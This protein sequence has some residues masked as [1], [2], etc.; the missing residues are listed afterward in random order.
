MGVAVLSSA[1]FENPATSRRAKP[2]VSHFVMDE[3]RVDASE[4]RALEDW[5]ALL[6]IRESNSGPQ[7]HGSVSSR[8][9]AGDERDR[10]S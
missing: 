6:T 3:M 7:F 5:T 8:A 2:L 4:L 9:V 1:L 10:A